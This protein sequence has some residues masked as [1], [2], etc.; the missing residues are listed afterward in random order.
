MPRIPATEDTHVFDLSSQTE[1]EDGQGASAPTSSHSPLVLSPTT[2]AAAVPSFPP[3]EPPASSASS[4]AAGG[5][6]SALSLAAAAAG[7]GQPIA[8]AKAPR[9]SKNVDVEAVATEAAAVDADAVDPQSSGGDSSGRTVLVLYVGGTLGMGLNDKGALE[10]LK[11]YLTEKMHEM[12]ELKAKGMPK[13]DILE[14]EN[15]KDSSDM[16]P[17]DWCRMARDIAN[18]YYKYDGFLVCHGTDTMHYTAAALAFMLEN[19]A[20]PVIVTGAMVPFIEPYNDARRNI[21]VAMMFA[22]SDGLCEVCLFCNDFLLRGCRAVKCRQTL[23]A[24]ESPNFPPLAVMGADQFDLREDLLQRQPTGAFSPVTSLRPSNVVSLLITAGFDDVE[25]VNFVGEF[26][27]GG[28]AARRENHQQTVVTTA[29]VGNAAVAAT[30]TSFARRPIDCIIFEISG[31]PLTE[32]HPR[33]MLGKVL[34][35]AADAGIV[36]IV[37]NHDYKG[38]LRLSYARA[39]RS[40][41]ADA[42]LIHD[43]TSETAVVKAKYLFGRGLSP[44]A[45][46]KWM[47]VSIRGELTPVALDQMIGKL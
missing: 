10:P 15:L 38:P 34:R 27:K 7:D 2:H 26:G 33:A 13:F 1:H 6:P 37:S 21:I 28:V 18:N 31:L 32:A 4:N 5:G 20:K 14:Y 3:A 30:T 12:P 9:A 16:G 8:A 43:M 22:A 44:D 17:A 23:S 41:C 36:V 25:F 35:A 45:V 42:T 47:P 39:L 29:A 40:I 46:R 24:F 11:G 19:L